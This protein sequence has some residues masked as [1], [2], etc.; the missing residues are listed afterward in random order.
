MSDAIDLRA[1]HLAAVEADTPNVLDA[2]SGDVI[3]QCETNQVLAVLRDVADR[4]PVARIA[5]VGYEVCLMCAETRPYTPAGRDL[6]DPA[7]TD[8]YPHKIS[9]PWLRAVRLVGRAVP[10]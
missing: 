4:Q 9:C 10:S 7:F 8:N 5:A 6:D 2:T 3:R 1:A